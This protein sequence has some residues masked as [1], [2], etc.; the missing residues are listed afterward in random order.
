MPRPRR[1]KW[2]ITLLTQ[3]FEVGE[4]YAT[5]SMADY[6]CI[7]SFAILAR[8]EKTVTV[9]VYGKT[10]CRRLRVRSGVEYFK[11]FGTYSMC[12]VI[13]AD[14]DASELAKVDA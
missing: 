10:V 6:D 5:R 14:K 8:T 3:K 7:Y 13:Y 11:P 12:P 4:K 9:L 2:Q 1:I